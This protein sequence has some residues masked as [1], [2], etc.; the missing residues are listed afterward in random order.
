MWENKLAEKDQ[1]V[2]LG[3]IATFK[4]VEKS[5]TISVAE[6]LIK[7]TNTA[8]AGK[9]EKYCKKSNQFNSS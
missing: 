9:R 8:A 6:L 2:N 1:A 3:L 4:S 5:F 7:Q